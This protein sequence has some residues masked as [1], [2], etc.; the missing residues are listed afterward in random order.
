MTLT[1]KAGLEIWRVS[2]EEP[3]N[4]LLSDIEDTMGNKG[5]H[6]RNMN[7]CVW[8]L[9]LLKF[10]TKK[11]KYRI[12]LMQI[13]AIVMHKISI[14]PQYFKTDLFIE[15]CTVISAKNILYDQIQGIDGFF[16]RG[17]TS[18]SL[19]CILDRMIWGTI[20]SEHVSHHSQENSLNRY[21]I[22]L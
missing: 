11:F 18:H 20:Y 13:R 22:V 4:L 8:L 5:S 17:D 3:F 12:S 9:L 1:S 2:F 10:S 15:K 6:Y 14:P 19:F 16:E 21:K 7:N